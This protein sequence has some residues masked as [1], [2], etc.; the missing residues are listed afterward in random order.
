M[1]SLKIM[2]RRPGKSKAY[3][4]FFG[5]D[6]TIKS[7]ITSKGGVVA[8]IIDSS[9]VNLEPADHLRLLE[10]GEIREPLMEARDSAPTW[11]ERFEKA[12]NYKDP[13][14]AMRM[15]GIRY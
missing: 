6:I 8:D 12:L 4:A 9:I 13:G 3:V 1:Q 15:C 11:H 7:A 2:Y 14:I 5:Q 10:S